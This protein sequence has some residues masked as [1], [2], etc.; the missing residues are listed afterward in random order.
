MV[1]EPEPYRLLPGELVLAATEDAI[2]ALFAQPDHFV[3]VSAGDREWEGE[4][5]VIGLVVGG[6]ARAYPIRLLSNHEVVND[7]VGGRPVLVTWCPLCYSA[8]VFDR[9]VEGREITFGV[10][11]YLLNSN[12]VLYDHPTNT[13][14][15]QLLGQGIKGA[16]SGTRLE[17]IP[18]T[19]TSWSDWKKAFPDTEVLSA[20]ALELYQGEVVDPY[21][22]YYTSGVAGLSGSGNTDSRL[23]VNPLV[24]GLAAGE[25]SVA[26]PLDRIQSERLIN[27]QRGDLPLAVVYDP[28]RQSAYLYHRE[29]AGRGLTFRQGLREGT[30]V[31]LETRSRW[32]IRTGQAVRGRLRGEELT[33]INAPLVFWF[34]WSSHYP[35]TQ[36]FGLP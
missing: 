5:P 7:H 31:D 16:H 6:E 29:A 21:V 25:I 26:Y 3:A 27:D 22:G 15:S 36:V 9:V 2:P 20:R 4:E 10:S 8:I 1:P 12:L 18:S 14:W 23:K 32:D 30:M 19:L 28:A 11:G 17:V 13:L 34:A 35:D 33:R 24:L